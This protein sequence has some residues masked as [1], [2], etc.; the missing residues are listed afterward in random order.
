VK[1]RDDVRQASNQQGS[2]HVAVRRFPILWM[3]TITWDPVAGANPPKMD[4]PQ[5][6][7][8][9]TFPLGSRTDLRERPL[10]AQRGHRLEA[11]RLPKS[12]AALCGPATA[13]FRYLRQKD[14]SDHPDQRQA[15]PTTNIGTRL[16]PE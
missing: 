13:D 7:S 16:L 2:V 8:E 11:A 12:L 4:G 15:R 9:S 5:G 14:R 6:A 3:Q 10:L 1:G